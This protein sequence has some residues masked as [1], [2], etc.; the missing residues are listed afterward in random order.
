VYAPFAT[1]TLSG[2]ARSMRYSWLEGS[3]CVMFAFVKRTAGRNCSL[4]ESWNF[5]VLSPRR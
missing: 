5:W 4:R 3:A 2:A 1:L